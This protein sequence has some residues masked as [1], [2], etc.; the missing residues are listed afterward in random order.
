MKKI[1]RLI[2]LLIGL[3]MAG[4]AGRALADDTNT[5]VTVSGNM[6]CAKCKLHL[7]TT[8]QNV[9]QVD[10]DGTTVNYFLVN[11]DVSN[12]KHED[13]CMTDGEKVTATGT[14]E[15]KDGK[16]TLTPT[17]IDVSK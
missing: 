2:T 16:L 3:A 10:K 13:I 4:F 12:G 8:C 17:K 11:N 7:T 6:V 14:V 5:T 9:V 1:N 15:T